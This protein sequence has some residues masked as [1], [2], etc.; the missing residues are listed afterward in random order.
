VGHW[1]KSPGPA[2]AIH[3][4]R[5]LRHAFPGR[6]FIDSERVFHPLSTD[7][8]MVDCILALYHYPTLSVMPALDGRNWHLDA[9]R[10]AP[11]GGE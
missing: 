4:L 5:P 1:R 6:G 11:P 8:R 9:W 7:G 2:P 3:A 10:Q